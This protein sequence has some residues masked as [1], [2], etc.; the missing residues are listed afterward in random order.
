ME[1]DDYYKSLGFK[2]GLEIHQRLATRHKLFCSCSARPSTDR[3]IAIVSRT[4]RA[5]AGE[6]GAV[7]VSTAFESSRGRRFIYNVYRRESC[8]V[9]VDEEPPHGVDGEAVGIALMVANSLKM[10]M[11]DEIEPM[12]KGVVDGS[13]PSAFQRSMLIG[14]DGTLEVNGKTIPVYAAFLEEESSGIVS[15]SEESVEYN[16]DRLGIP[17]IEIDTAPEISSPKE[18]KDVALRIGLLL[19]LTGKVQRG[20]G[21]IRQD[22]NVS[23]KGGTRVEIKGVQDLSTMDV[24][25]DN[26]VKRQLN[27][28]KIRVELKRRKA[29]V[30]DAVNVTSVFSNSDAK[31]IGASVKAGGVVIAFGLYGF[32]G[33]LGQEINPDRR[34]GSEI[35]DYARM[36]GVKGIIH[37]DEELSKYGISDAELSALG[38]RLELGKDG[39]FVLVAA[40]ARA[41]EKAI[42]F[43]RNRC[44]MA[45][46]EV[47]GET[48]A[49]MEN[50]I[51]RFMRPIPGGSR[52]YP[53]T[54]AVPVEVTGALKE[55]LGKRI[56]PDSIAK[57][58]EK[59]IGN[60]QLAAQM[61]WSE[62]L[63]L[64]NYL[65]EKKAAPAV[66]IAVVLL[67][68]FRELR[69][70]GIDAGRIP[71]D[72]LA[73]IFAT[74]SK[75]MITKL[76]VNELL[77]HTPVSGPDVERIIE[78]KGLKRIK[79]RDLEKL[80]HELKAQGKADMGNVMSR[81]RMNVD[82]EELNS[83]L[84]KKD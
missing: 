80:L 64:Y 39:S 46:S 33:L 7:D 48:R 76:A 68:K 73:Y 3:K 2:C 49:A 57:K 6:L 41:A 55:A 81:Y 17:L 20:I 44:K 29:R 9:D 77:R 16:V 60:R 35:S 72:V 58:L 4:Q 82:G 11:P 79:G 27:L 62:E 1:S 10:K 71:D 50:G 24:L 22:V 18:A 75:G 45:M 12:R 61:L 15:S 36:A 66:L 21:T 47:P 52:M 84:G 8:L 30:G 37:S 56:D 70:E 43:A 23:I 83:L 32:K 78:Q 13:D 54:D 14:Y 28:V 67:E 59:E 63:P 26:E 65:L 19:R 34:L 25:V 40:P 51:T 42:E 69:R 31:I 38:K 74:Y 5:V 53:E